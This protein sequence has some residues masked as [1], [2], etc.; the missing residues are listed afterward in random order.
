MSPS[1]KAGS[2]TATGEKIVITA[3]SHDCGGRCVLKTHVKDGVIT[4]IE[5]DSEDEPQLRACVR[6]RAYRQRVYGA[7]RI[8]YPMKRVGERGEGKFQRISWDEALDA[9]SKELLRVKKNYGPGAIFFFGLSGSTTPL[10][11]Q[12]RPMFRLFNMFGG[13][14]LWWGAPSFEAST[15]ASKM[16]LGTT[17]TGN[18]RDDVINSKLII[19][20]GHNPANTV[21]TTNASFYLAKAKE[22][23]I[24]IVSVDP[25]YT[26]SAITYAQQ[27]IPIRPGTDAAMLIAM[28]YVMITENLHKKDF[29]DK[30]TVGFDKFQDYVLG[31]GDGQ[32]K[33]PQWA[34]AITDVPAATIIGLAREYATKHPA[35]L[36]AGFGPGRSANGEQFH[37]AAITLAAMTGNIGIHGGNAAGIE[38]TPYGVLG[39]RLATGENLAVKDPRVMK[40]G[41]NA[42]SRIDK[43]GVRVHSS[44][45]AD[46]ILQGTKGGYPADIRL[47]YVAASNLVTQ[48][49]NTKKILEALK[50]VESIIVHEQFMTNTAKY[51]DILLPVNTFMEK[52]DIGEPW[53]SGPW[54]IYLDKA[55]ESLYESKSD[56]QIA[57][58]LAPRLGIANYDEG[59]DDVAFLKDFW[60]NTPGVPDFDTFRKKGV[61]KYKMA[62]P[63]V[64]FKEQ[65]ADPKSHPFATPSGKIEIYSQQMDRMN[66]PL[67]PPIPKYV[68]M[69]EGHNDP[70]AKKYPLQLIS[71]HYKARDHSTF[72]NTPWL[73]EL[74]TQSVWMNPADA[75]PRG[76]KNG[77][78]VKIFND[79]GTIKIPVK[80]TNRLRPG[81]VDIQQGAWYNPDKDGVDRGGC[82]NV[83][84]K[85]DMSPAG[86]FCSNTGLV[87]IEKA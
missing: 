23:G 44:K 71:G 7:D 61:F 4:R 82:P 87:Q 27:W 20:W 72:A 51:A 5:T 16:T 8:Q 69:W 73:A 31:T 12:R 76:I 59:K 28:A 33:T 21:W 11:G 29:L 15:F 10:H 64:S 14:S 67:L 19:L 52:F 9:V 46:A 25:R 40:E 3:C 56:L 81:V 48:F 50:K 80:V 70:L 53:M 77:D 68:E 43:T 1:A 47:L 39:K 30:Y 37:H 66:N 6:G 58:E 26:D 42:Y 60:Q 84:L 62:E 38:G 65:I 41:L 13:C 24:K 34:E 74:E 63:Y 54:L 75:Q 17:Q 35:C 32:P 49:P 85:D 36:I 83:L 78:L 22:A 2:T 57:R 86:A 79:R 55:V 45:V 18:T